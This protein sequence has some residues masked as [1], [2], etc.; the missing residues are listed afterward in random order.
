M[1]GERNNGHALAMWAQGIFKKYL[2]GAAT[3]EL[4]LF[5]CMGKDQISCR[6]FQVFTLL[7]RHQQKYL[8]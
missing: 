4:I 2:V 3:V 1:Q 7:I 8:G 5:H 6:S